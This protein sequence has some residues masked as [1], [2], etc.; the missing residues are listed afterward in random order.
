M[1]AFALTVFLGAF[2]LFQVQ[3]LLGRYI[4]PWFGGTPSVWTS[5][6]LFF[7]A[8][9]LVGYT[10]AHGVASRLKPGRQALVHIAAIAISLL[11][12]PIDPDAEVWKTA[13]EGDPTGTILLLLLVTAG[14]PYVILAATSPLLQ[15]WFH[16]EHPTRSPYRLYALSNAGSLLA[17]LSY[18]FVAEP[19]FTVEMQAT[20]WSVSYAVFA[21]AC[22]WCAWGLRGVP[23]NRVAPAAPEETP[24]LQQMLKWLALSAVG[25][26]M[27]LATTNQMS[28]E[29]AVVPFLWV[30][31]LALYLLT[32][33]FCFESDRWYSRT[34]YGF[35]LA[36]TV[37]AACAAMAAGGLFP[38]AVQTIIFSSVLFV[39]C[40]VCHGELARM[41]PAGE[42]ATRFYLTLAAGGALG[43]ALVA[44]VAPRVFPDFW[45]FPLSLAA[46]CLVALW[47][48]LH[49]AKWRPQ[50]GSAKMFLAPP[51]ALLVA[52]FT[53]GYTLGVQAL[54]ESVTTERNFY[55]VLRVTEA[56][57]ESGPFRRLTHGKTEHGTQYTTDRKRR[58]PTTYFGEGTGAWLALENHPKRKRGEPLSIG[59]VG[60][61]AG[62]L[63]AYAQP[64]DRLVFY[65]INPAV[66]RTAREHFT[67]LADAPVSVE[68]LGGDARIRMER[69][70]AS[71][72][73]QGFDI[74]LVDAFSSGAIP[75]HLLTAEA[76]EI[77]AQR[78][79]E[80][81]LLLFHISN[82]F[83]D[84]APV[85]RGMAERLGMT[86]LRMTSEGDD[87][88]GLNDAVWMILTRNRNF[89]ED[90]TVIERVDA[91]QPSETLDWSDSFAGLWQALR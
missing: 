69:E 36:L 11:A 73:P 6:M 80:D 56:E 51:P 49:G 22:A 29:I 78:L 20:I 26:T 24:T 81:G 33:I 5:C 76:G 71:A 39:G 28:Q 45:E 87:A 57:D 85:L 88:R 17:L 37:P 53:V 54:E 86:A 19:L 65:E 4:L 46:C 31:P 83:L 66:V 70:L 12:L 30:L 67:Y 82:R 64:G 55:G 91:D 13:D 44:L 15:H 77:Y 48:W 52:L 68:V 21:A 84:L 40:M 8:L 9:L 63:A 60:L 35:G 47:G 43:G 41:R 74:L 10:Y 62:T 23:Q 14:L 2:L 89:L 7:Q 75:I 79:T 59:V 61:G 90:A 18:P 3:P 72:T 50:A 58:T 27:L 16:A 32:F 1:V 42:Q 25:S 34:A 38:L